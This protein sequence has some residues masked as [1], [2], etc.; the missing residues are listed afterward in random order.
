[1]HAQSPTSTAIRAGISPQIEHRLFSFISK[2]WRGQPL[3]S[4]E[5]II[6][7][8]A[9][10]TTNTGLEAYVRL[11]ENTYPDKIAVTDTQLA[12]VNITRHEFHPE[13]NYTI[14]P[15]PK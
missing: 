14:K 3:V 11:D 15:S 13:W 7:L 9:A 2:N 4:Y 6:N 12:A 8:I 1:L 10:T 5:V